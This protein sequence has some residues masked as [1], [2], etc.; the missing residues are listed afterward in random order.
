MNMSEYL[1]ALCRIAG[2][3][4]LVHVRGVRHNAVPVVARHDQHL[5]GAARL[6]AACLVW[7]IA[8]LRTLFTGTGTCATA[9]STK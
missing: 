6:D 3:H 4:Q 7:A 2:L 1:S 9:H 8:L 5:Q